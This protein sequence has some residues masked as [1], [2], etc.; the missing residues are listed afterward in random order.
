LKK[1]ASLIRIIYNFA[2][3]SIKVFRYLAYIFL[4]F[5]GIVNFASNNYLPT[6]NSKQFSEEISEQTDASFSFL[7]EFADEIDDEDSEKNLV[8]KKVK[9]HLSINQIEST[10]NQFIFLYA[11][12]L[13]LLNS[14]IDLP[15][16]FLS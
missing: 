11:K 16:P 9:Q 1:I 5:I 14:Y 4:L 10:R 13:T 3:Y 2:F 12:R 8:L 7:N 15:P 6:Q